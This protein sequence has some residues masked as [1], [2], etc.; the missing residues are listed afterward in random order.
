MKITSKKI[1]YIVGPLIDTTWKQDYP[2]NY[3]IDPQNETNVL[4]GCVGVAGAQVIKYHKFP[5][6]ASGVIDAYGTQPEYDID[7]YEYHW[8]DMP[9]SLSA[10]SDLDKIKQTSSLIY[11]CALGAE[12]FFGPG[13]PGLPGRMMGFF[14][15]NLSYDIDMRHVIVESDLAYTNE[16]IE[17]L[18]ISELDNNRPLIVSIPGH[19]IVC[20]GYTDDGLFSLNYGWGFTPELKKLDSSGANVT[21]FIYGIQPAKKEQ[22]IITSLSCNAQELL[23]GMEILVTANCSAISDDYNGFAQFVIAD[24]NNMVRS[25]ISPL[26]EISVDEDEVIELQLNLTVPSDITFGERSIQLVYGDKQT[27][28]RS[29]RDD[30]GETYGFPVITKR[31]I[32]SRVCVKEIN[33]IEDTVYQGDL[34]SVDVTLISEMNRETV[35]SFYLVDEQENHLYTLWSGHVELHS[36]TFLNVDLDFK[37]PT[38]EKSYRLVIVENPEDNNSSSSSMLIPAGNGFNYFSVYVKNALLEYGD[39][40]ILLENIDTSISRWTA[41]SYPFRVKFHANEN[42]KPGV[43]LYASITDMDNNIITKRGGTVKILSDGD[44]EVIIS[45]RMPIVAED[46]E[47]KFNTTYET[48]VPLG[49]EVLLKPQNMNILNPIGIRVSYRNHYDYFHLVKSINLDKDVLQTSEIFCLQSSWLYNLDDTT[50]TA[51]V[52]TLSVVI[53]DNFGNTYVIGED[54]Q[55]YGI[56]GRENDFEM[57]CEIPPEIESGDYT[58]FIQASNATNETGQPNE[59]I[60]GV[61]ESIIDYIELKVI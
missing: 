41:G 40:L 30:S 9:V 35:I 42:V 16:E 31:S 25:Y 45:L 53:K 10:F 50:T 14:R 3:Q 7:G 36:E 17:R 15:K 4:I 32:E 12:S 49:D 21:G 57:T 46:V 60:K 47:Y 20:D 24:K 52:F 13:T 19:C 1:N 22:F 59:Y 27:D 61:D 37:L 26:I 33:N 11:H 44:Y 34:V 51:V 8:D 23:P 56:V 43:N 39:D 55:A 38:P 48:V 5:D 29:L 18:F 58:L 6:R 28:L 2:Y 54:A